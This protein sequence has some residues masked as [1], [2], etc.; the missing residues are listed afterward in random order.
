MIKRL[1]LLWRYKII[2]IVCW[3]LITTAIL[4]FLIV[5]IPCLINYLI[6]QPQ[7]FDV[8]GDGTTWLS[9]WVTYIGAIV[10]LIMIFVTLYVLW[11]QLNQN[12]DE[13]EINREANEKLNKENRE[14]QLNIFKYQQEMQW[15]GEVRILGAEY[16]KMFNNN[17]LVV[18]QNAI[19]RNPNLSFDITK[20]I[21]DGLQNVKSSYLLIERQDNNA[22]E[23]KKQLSTRC[24][25]FS[26]V[27]KDVN[28]LAAYC[29]DFKQAREKNLSPPP[30]SKYSVIQ[31]SFSKDI[32]AENNFEE[33]ILF[34]INLLVKKKRE[35]VQRIN[36]EVSVLFVEYINKEQERIN[37]ILNNTDNNDKK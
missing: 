35:S 17:N 26:S 1:E 34:K 27:I 3:V 25:I 9:F 31:E 5:G 29:L 12:H 11:K 28:G 33:N 13:N 16:I 19:E 24:D 2:R 37:N 4:V 22:Q 14:I 32:K 10:S 18:A 15:L 23:L 36:L 20:E 6:L 21:L 30:L 8:V 7:Q